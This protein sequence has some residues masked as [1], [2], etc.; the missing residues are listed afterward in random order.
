MVP[1]TYFIFPLLIRKS[2][3]DWD[4]DKNFPF[5]FFVVIWSV[6]F[7]KL[8]SILDRFEEE[9]DLGLFEI[10]DIINGRKRQIGNVG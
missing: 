7:S 10:F 9:L 3:V 2:L 6:K 5:N 4:H 1:S 8:I